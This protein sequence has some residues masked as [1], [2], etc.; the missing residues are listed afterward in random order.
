MVVVTWSNRTN[1]N[2]YILSYLEFSYNI[3]VEQTFAEKTGP[4]GYPYGTFTLGAWPGQFDSPRVFLWELQTTYNIH[5]SNVIKI[6]LST[7]IS[8]YVHANESFREK[9]AERDIGGDQSNGDGNGCYILHTYINTYVCMC[10]WCEWDMHVFTR[11][12]LPETESSNMP[13]F[14]YFFAKLLNPTFIFENN[15]SSTISNTDGSYTTSSSP[16]HIHIESKLLFFLVNI[17]LAF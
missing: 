1:K 4:L 17:I 2:V 15:Y 9:H 7:A 10:V 11:C 6:V 13:S 16:S 8:I 3:G 12:Y 5:Y 14:G